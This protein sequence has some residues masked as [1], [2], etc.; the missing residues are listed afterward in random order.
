[1]W[2]RAPPFVHVSRPGNAVTTHEHDHSHGFRTFVPEMQDG[3]TGELKEPQVDSRIACCIAGGR[4]VRI[5]H[6]SAWRDA[7][8]TLYFR[9]IKW[10]RIATA[11]TKHQDHSTEEVL[12]R[13]FAQ[14]GEALHPFTCRAYALAEPAPVYVLRLLLFPAPP[15]I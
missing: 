4:N 1:M 2:C 9:H 12:R 14:R 11:Q 10:Y 6:T 8:S 5:S 3:Q 7:I 13:C 15:A